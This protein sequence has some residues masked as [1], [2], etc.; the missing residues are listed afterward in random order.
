MRSA[1]AVRFGLPEI[2]CEKIMVK[3][4]IEEYRHRAARGDTEALFELA[5]GHFRG[6]LVPKDFQMAIALLR[7]ME[8]TSPQLARFNIAKM[9]YLAGDASFQDDIRVDC[10]AGFGPALYLMGIYLKKSGD[11]T[12][13]SEAVSYFRAA[14][15]ADHLP[16]KILL[17]RYSSLGLGVASRLRS[18]PI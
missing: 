14:S 7:Q 17:W 6:D 1:N 4:S 18:L 12:G 8:E 3:T 13:A 5:W 16:S 9:K 11:Q 10:D 2:D 15:E